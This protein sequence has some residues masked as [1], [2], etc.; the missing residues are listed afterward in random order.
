MSLL[1]LVVASALL[2]AAAAIGEEDPP[3]MDA[4]PVD[5][6]DED[7]MLIDAEVHEGGEGAEVGDMGD[8]GEHEE[9]SI[10]DDPYK[11]RQPPCMSAHA[12]ASCC[13]A[14]A[15]THASQSEPQC[16]AIQCGM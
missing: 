12:R 6:P 3:P 4:P 2:A 16:G 5:A 1:R 14:V 10:I 13:D 11:V 9:G 15:A 8:V 7:A